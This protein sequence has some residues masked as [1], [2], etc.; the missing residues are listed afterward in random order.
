MRRDAGEWGG[1]AWSKLGRYWT[2]ALMMSV[3]RFL[4]AGCGALLSLVCAV[5]VLAFLVDGV[6][7][8]APLM[9]TLMEQHAPPEETS[10]PGEHYPAMAEMIT[11]YLS[12]R[13][14]EFQFSWTDEQG[15]AYLAFHEKEQRHMADVKALFDLDRTVLLCAVVLAVLLGLG[16]Y[17]LRPCRRWTARGVVWGSL[18]ILAALTGLG[19]WAALD[20]NGLFVLFHRLSFSNDLWL[21]NPA[22]DLLIRLMPLE[23]FIHYAAILGGTWLGALLLML[24]AAR[25]LST[26]WKQ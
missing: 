22:T 13:A 24:A 21:L 5:L 15:T 9:L 25:R 26:R 17:G 11:D 23:F 19:V 12:G 1:G 20:F 18:A 7:G 16:A 14:G 3:R 4:A 2:G 8:S 6:G 10:L